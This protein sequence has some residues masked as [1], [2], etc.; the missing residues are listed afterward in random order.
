ME[1]KEIGRLIA[2]GYE[3]FQEVRVSSMNRMRD[4]IRRKIEGLEAGKVEE[5]KNNKDYSKQYKDA[6]LFE[7]LEKVNEQK[8]ISNEEYAYL[9]D[10]WNAVVDTKKVENQYKKLMLQYIKTELLYNE[11]L[12]K[13]KGIGEVIASKLIAKLGYCERFDTVSRLWSYCGYG[14]GENGTAIK[15]KKGEQLKFNLRLRSFM[16]VVSDCLMKT[17]KGYYRKLYDVEKEKQLNREYPVGELKSKFNR[18]ITKPT[19]KESK[20]KKVYKDKGYK[21]T[22]TKLSK[23]H[24]HKRA[25]RKVGKQF[26]SHYWEAS[27]TLIGLPIKKTYVEGVLLH[28]H[29]VDFKE[30]LLLE[31]SLKVETESEG[32]ETEA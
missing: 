27:R 4:I 21:E 12:S 20:P 14:V 17:N 7:K 26:L 13:I 30:M 9:I 3:G 31:D 2:N 25:L 29:I 10:F 32:S 22:D 11:Y 15:R 6:E 5:K 8:K 1:T 19:T 28:T 16:F 23:G 18:S 24:A